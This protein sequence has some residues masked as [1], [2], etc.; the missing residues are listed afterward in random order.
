VYAVIEV[1]GH[2][3][4]VT[5]GDKILVDRKSADGAKTRVLMLSDGDKITTDRASLDK[6]TVTLDHV[7]EVREQQARVMKFKTKQARSCKRTIGGRRVRQQYSVSA[8]KA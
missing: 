4:R 6:A 2:Q 3:F 5:K 1:D 8:V 7:G